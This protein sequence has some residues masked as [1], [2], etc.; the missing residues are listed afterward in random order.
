MGFLESTRGKLLAWVSSYDYNTLLGG[1]LEY[2][3]T[4]SSACDIP[5]ISLQPFEHI[6]YLH[7]VS[8]SHTT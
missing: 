7:L 3:M 1:V 8:L 6:A 2:P 4:A 5:P